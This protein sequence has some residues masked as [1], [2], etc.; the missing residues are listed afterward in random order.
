MSDPHSPSDR[1]RALRRQATAAT[2]PAAPPTPQRF[3]Y[4]P[5]VALAAVLVALAVAGYLI[6]RPGT[7]A[8]DA[9]SPELELC[10]RFIAL[11]NA[12]DP[13]A[14]DLLGPAPVVPAEPVSPEEADRIH[15]EF[16][17]RENYRIADVRAETSEISGPG[18]RF[19]LMLRGGV[20][21]PRIAQTKPGG[22]DVINRVVSNPEVMVRVA[23]GTIRAIGWRAHHEADEKE[24]TEEEKR[25]FR[26]ALEEQQREQLRQ[27]QGT[28]RR[29]G[30]R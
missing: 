20:S 17:L 26:E 21:S 4:W 12:N 29:D 15:A 2:P 14:N 7:P 9:T 28:G 19:V 11:K 18:A 8:G 22:V 27:M 16:F 25:Q 5:A 10:R 23:D 3:R 13:A 24:P 6:Y 30:G 1:A